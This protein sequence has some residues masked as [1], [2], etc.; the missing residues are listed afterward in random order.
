[1]KYRGHPALI[2]FRWQGDVEIFRV[3][4]PGSKIINAPC[5]VIVNSIRNQAV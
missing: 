5:T 1:M 3:A 4:K 2:G